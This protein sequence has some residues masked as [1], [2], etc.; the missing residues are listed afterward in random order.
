[1]HLI[2][3]GL[4]WVLSAIT[5]YLNVKVGD[6]K[7]WAWSMSLLNQVL[8]FAWIVL[9]ESWGFLPMNIGLAIVFWRNARKWERQAQ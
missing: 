1:M 4:P 7:A 3:H 8:W 5:L 9:T 6:R 2:E